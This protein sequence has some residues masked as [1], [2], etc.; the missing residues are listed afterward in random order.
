MGW[1]SEQISPHSEL[2]LDFCRAGYCGSSESAALDIGTG[3]GLV[4]LAALHAGAWVVANDLE[5]RHLR[6]LQRRAENETSPEER[7]R[8]DVAAG[9][10]P[11]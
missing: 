10:F 2:F 9:P 7:S 4:A 11:T 1:I 3:Y 8:L 5:Q 6:E